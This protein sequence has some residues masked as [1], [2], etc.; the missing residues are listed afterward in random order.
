K[1]RKTEARG[2]ILIGDTYF[3]ERNW[4]NAL[5]QY[6]KAEKLLK[7]NQPHDQIQLSIRLGKTYR[8]LPPPPTGPNTN[9]GIAIDK[10]TIAFNANPTSL[11]LALELGGA[12]IEG[13]QDAKATALTDRLI[14]SF[15]QAKVNGENRAAIL[16]LAGKSLFNQHKL[17]ESRA[18]FEAA[19]EL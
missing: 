15:D 8:R 19:R 2:Y 12:Y 10:L 9:L 3:A 6:L 17:K 14:A 5:D 13:R 4:A 11:E 7:P 16:V 18:R 1:A